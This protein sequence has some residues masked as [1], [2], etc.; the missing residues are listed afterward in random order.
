MCG[1]PQLSSLCRKSVWT[2]SNWFAVGF[3]VFQALDGSQTGRDRRLWGALRDRLL[4]WSLL[5]RSRCGLQGTW[6]RPESLAT[7]AHR[8][9]S[10]L[11]PPAHEAPSSRA[12]CHFVLPQ[13]AALDS[14]EVALR[15]I[16]R[17]ARV[18]SREPC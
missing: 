18:K 10:P 15:T 3:E 2:A 9:I 8:R 13:L 17:K 14:T 12:R 7:K 16:G 4:L 11:K 5:C 1:R 6:I